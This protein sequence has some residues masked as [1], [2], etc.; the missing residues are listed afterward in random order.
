[1]SWKIQA[2]TKMEV[3]YTVLAGTMQC[4]ERTSALSYGPMPYTNMSEKNVPT[5]S[6]LL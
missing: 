6:R 2:T 1:M 3:P 4:L 5:M